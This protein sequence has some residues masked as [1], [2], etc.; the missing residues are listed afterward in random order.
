MAVLLYA[1]AVAM[2][3]VS[4]AAFNWSSIAE[5]AR[6]QQAVRH[7][8]DVRRS[9]GELLRDLDQAEM[10]VQAPRPDS[11]DTDPLANARRSLVELDSL[12]EADLPQQEFIAALNGL[13]LGR[14][15]GQD[16]A[17]VIGEA[18][19]IA[20]TIDAQEASLLSRRD[21]EARR[22][23]PWA[24]RTVL[25]GAAVSLG[26]LLMVVFV[27][28]RELA[29]RT[30]DRRRLEDAKTFL[31]LILDNI[32]QGVFWKD[33]E[34]R[35]AGCNQRMVQ[36]L[37]L[38]SA[39]NIVGMTDE[40]LYGP[41]LAESFRASDKPILNEGQVFADT[42][43]YRQMADGRLAHLE[44]QK[45]P[46]R[47][48]DGTIIGVIGTY[49]DIT[50]RVRSQAG[51]MLRQRAI[52]ASVNAIFISDHTA[53]D[54]PIV[55]VNPAFES[56]TGYTASEV[57]GRNWRFL[58]GELHDQPG[59]AR[60][61]TAIQE[62]RSG[63]AL[64]RNFR[65]DGTP[66]WNDLRV[67][68]VTEID[69]H[70]SHYV[71]V[72]NDVTAIKGYQEQLEHHATHDPLTALP[73]RS[74]ALDRLAQALLQAQRTGAAVTVAY[75]DLDNFR[76]V[77]DAFGR[78]SG[79]RVLQLVASRLRD[80]L[81]STDTVGRLAGDEF[82]LILPGTAGAESGSTEIQR[83][84]EVFADPLVVNGVEVLIRASVGASVYPKDAVEAEA[85][86][87]C[88]NS[89]M[90]QAKS[91][92]RNAFQ[93]YGPEMNERV[94]DRLGLITALSR[95]VD[96]QELLL[97]YQPRV[98]VVSG[99]IT[100][101]EALVRWRRAN[102]AMV[103]PAE[104]I[105]LAEESG[106][107]EPI[108]GWVLNEACR[109]LAEWRR[110][111]ALQIQM[112]VNL[113]ARQFRDRSLVSEVQRVL[114]AHDLAPSMLELELTESALMRDVDAAA[115][116]MANLKAV[117]VSLA[118]D[119]FGTGYSSLAYL[120]TFPLDHLKIDRSFVR[121]INTRPADLAI[122]KTVIDL[123]RCLNMR[124]V[125][126]GVEQRDQLELLRSMECDE[127]QGFLFSKPLP[128]NEC[129]PLLVSQRLG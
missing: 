7:S 70:V 120:K 25:V 88:A 80:Q 119:D 64:L 71:G 75:V 2:F 129:L 22:S 98:D 122:C 12:A 43:H 13:L 3:V 106:L 34:S 91:A 78:D 116:Q 27:L 107:I 46:L 81:R 73:N 63:G 72:L 103:S 53:L 55:Y 101:V 104:F 17:K 118:I 35:Y 10:D 23:A 89:A 61:R 42:E 126:E 77:N 47:A 4:N 14:G 44:I 84:L 123:A 111:G 108:G 21:V 65:K 40:L 33:R 59:I 38:G 74:L 112:A 115:G 85:L 117:G 31:Q 60:I 50:E 1:A 28:Q 36:D 124:T 8:Y 49:S 15:T 19:T 125:A 113:S 56:I 83:V 69:G 20:Q 114:E 93:Y 128:A 87:N 52:E 92:G 121:D 37:G 54:E 62:G 66:F 5:L 127:I 90:I 110:E 41:E 29:R 24:K 79:D 9:V 99:R 45:F 68:P 100:G 109:Q 105:P 18:R 95:A 86:L 30:L 32:P 82:V 51:L 94:H 11:S 39:D 96:R 58:H 76:H 97:H 67:A 16:P 102:G 6:T 48:A 57:L 26:T